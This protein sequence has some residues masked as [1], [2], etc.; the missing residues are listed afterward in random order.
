MQV[1]EASKMLG[2]ES[3]EFCSLYGLKNHL[4]KLPKKLEMEL[5]QEE[6]K[7]VE[8]QAPEKTVNPVK[9]VKKEEA[10]VQEECP[11]SK[12]DL[13]LSLRL[14]GGKSPYFKWRHLIG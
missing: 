8:E 6:K 14:L 10:A 7:I 12:K 5:F 4:S 3:K 11:I 13:E 1:Y 9:A 2:I